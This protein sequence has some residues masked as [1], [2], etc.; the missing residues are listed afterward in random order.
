MHQSVLVIEVS[1]WNVP[2]VY[3]E[4][5]AVLVCSPLVL[6]ASETCLRGGG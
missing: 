5:E 3:S 4:L 2:P 1:I 6:L